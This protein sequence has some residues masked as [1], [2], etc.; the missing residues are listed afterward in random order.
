MKK[1]IFKVQPIPGSRTDKSR[2]HRIAYE[3]VVDA[4][5]EDER[6]MGWYY[7]LENV[8]QFPFQAECAAQRSVS[9][10]RPGDKADVVGM[11]PEEECMREMFVMIRW[12]RRRLAVPLSQLQTLRATAKTRQAV[13]DWHYWIKK[14]YQF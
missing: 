11:P 2:E 3:I 6:A 7:Y 9:P 5:D 13:E 4:Y 8:L 10:L 1:R 12:G 14:G